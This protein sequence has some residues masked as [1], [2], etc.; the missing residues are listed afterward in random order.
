MRRQAVPPRPDHARIVREQGLIYND[1]VL[2]DGAV[3]PFWDESACY[4]FTLDEILRLER[5]TQALHDLCLAAV[6]HII[7]RRRYRELGIP[8]FARAAIEDTWERDTPSLY[9]RFDL[10]YDGAGPAKLLEYNADTPTSLLE[11]AVIQWYWLADT[12]PGWDQWNSLHER[13]VAAWR[14]HLP[15]LPN[16]RVHFAYTADEASGEDLMTVTYLRETAN[17]AGLS[18]ATLTMEEIGW[19][20]DRGR[21]VGPGREPLTTVFKLYPWEWMFAERF[22]PLALGNLH[23][24]GWIEP[25]WKCL[26]ANKAILAILWE[27]FPGH[28]NLLPA[29]LDGPGA[30]TAYA[31]KP[32]FGREGANVALVTP[33]SSY[34]QP[35]P[36]GAEG[37]VYQEYAPLPDVDGRYPVLG[38][39][40]VDG[41]AAGMGIREADTLITT[42]QSRFAPHRIDQA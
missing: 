27:L 7:T 30:L 31:R 40:V 13:L 39:W 6:E 35:G 28:P 11:A 8:D 26:L 16:R 34:A 4:A 2:P 18:T 5:T 24:T 20:H 36:Y 3:R 42:N 32:I 22:G 33:S 37:W 23:A 9:G 21:F 38:A 17:Q 15:R 25:P 41:E 1:T 10:R 19:D 29:F 14:R 12:H